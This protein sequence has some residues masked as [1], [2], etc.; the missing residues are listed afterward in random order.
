MFVYQIHSRLRGCLFILAALISQMEMNI[1]CILKQYV[2][3]MEQAE[4]GRQASRQAGRH[5]GR[6][7]LNLNNRECIIIMIKGIILR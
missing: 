3:P 7:I 1:M 2:Q 6:S 5:L 4:A